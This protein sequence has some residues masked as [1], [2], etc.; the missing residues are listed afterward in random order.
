MQIFPLFSKELLMRTEHPEDV[1]AHHSLRPGLSV[2]PHESGYD[3][4]QVL[5]TISHH[6]PSIMAGWP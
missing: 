2:K 1:I 6:I 3:I 4:E 5:A